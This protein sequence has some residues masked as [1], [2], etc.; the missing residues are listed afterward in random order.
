M[1]T[2]VRFS[3]SA[4]TRPARS[5]TFALVLVGSVLVAS[6]VAFMTYDLR[7]SL[8]YALELRGKK[9]ATMLLVGTGLAVAAVLFHTLTAN[10]ILTPS[11]IGLDSL[12]ILIQSIAVF[13]LGHL[14]FES[15][16]ER[17]RFLLA[18]SVMMVFAVALNA[19]FL[20][21]AAD[22]LPLLILAGI[23]MGGVFASLSA[24]VGRLLE[25]NEFMALQ[26]ALFA[27]VS[28]VNEQLLGFAALVVTAS[29]VVVFRMRRTLDAVAL[30]RTHA[31]AIGVDYDRI[32]RRLIILIALL[33]SVPTALV[34]PVTF[35]GLLAANV[36]Y[37]MART[38]RHRV[39]IPLAAMS[40]AALLIGA[41]FVLEELFAFETRL[42]V[43]VGFAGGLAFIVLVLRE[44]RQ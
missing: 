18:V 34:G 28:T 37:E 23:V 33:V 20:R 43:I 29:V 7:G 19:L 42:S 36:A 6:V 31:I 10:R 8:D 2:S 15:V 22:D 26:D 40:A 14:A 44:V 38:F 17:L 32:T 11:L 16:D 4:P 3:P 27:S 41:Q 12:Y 13:L 1:T 5:G 39:T 9:V 35:L 21:R 24:L 25:P 30:G